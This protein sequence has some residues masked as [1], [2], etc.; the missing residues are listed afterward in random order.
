MEALGVRGDLADLFARY[1]AINLDLWRRFEL[2]AVS[3]DFLKVE[4]FRHT[5]AGHGL[6]LD[7][8][9]ASDL[10]MAA[11]SETVVLIDGAVEICQALAAIGEVGIITN[12]IEHIQARRIATS[13]LHKHISF[14]ATSE[15]CGY[16]KPDERF[17]A[18]DDGGVLGRR[19]REA[20]AIGEVDDGGRSAPGRCPCTC[21]KGVGCG[22]ATE[23]QRHVRVCVDASGNHVF[24]GCV[25]YGV[26]AGREVCSE[27]HA[28]P[29]QHCN[30]AFS[31]D[32][33]IGIRSPC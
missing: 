16:A 13:S 21:F 27:E 28:A 8:A 14:V 5:F 33:H 18:D 2:G 10:Y 29:L 6:A 4:R 26:D 17:F 25:D 22:R 20:G 32:E 30:D 24:A 3:K 7:A 1:Q 31:V 23:W 19:A 11:L 15:A 12:G 9:R